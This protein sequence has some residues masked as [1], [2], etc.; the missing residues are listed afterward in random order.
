MPRVKFSTTLDLHGN[1][2]FLFCFNFRPTKLESMFST[3]CIMAAWLFS[4]NKVNIRRARLVLAW[5]GDSDRL[6]M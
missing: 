5:T 1:R 3:D 4:I 2:H 6:G